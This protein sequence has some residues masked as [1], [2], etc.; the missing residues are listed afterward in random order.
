MIEIKADTQD[1]LRR[2][3]LVS[4]ELKSK[5][6]GSG[7]TAAAKPIKATMAQLTP[8]DQGDLK[9]AV[10][11]RR[12]SGRAAARLSLFGDSVR[13]APGQVAILIGPNKK[14]GKRNQA[15]VGNLLEFGTKAHTIKPRGLRGVLRIGATG[16]ARKVRHPGIRPIKYMQRSLDANAQQIDD[17]FIEGVSKRLDKLISVV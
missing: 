7:L 9:R 5:A 13:L 10:N 8:V 11:Q 16:F 6:V 12:V 3:E 4:D 17:L 1:A 14:I 2:M 15:R